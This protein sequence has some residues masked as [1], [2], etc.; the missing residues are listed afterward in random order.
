L[1]RESAPTTTKEPCDLLLLFQ[2]N[3]RDETK[4]PCPACRSLN[5]RGNSYP[6]FGV[7]SWECQNLICPARSAFDRGN[8]FSVWSLIKREAISSPENQIPSSSLKRWKLDLVPGATESESIEMLL[9]HF[10]LQG[11]GVSLYNCK[12]EVPALERR[13]VKH[14]LSVDR[15]A[16][17]ERF[18]ASA[19]FHRFAI[20]R[21]AHA[22]SSVVRLD[23]G[24]PRFTLFCG[25]SLEALRLI[26][27]ESIDGAVT[28]P[29][30]FNARSYSVWPNVY[31]Y[32]YD[33]YNNAREVYR[34]LKSGSYYLFNIFDYFD[35]ELVITDSAMGKKRLLLSGYVVELFRRIGFTLAGNVVWSKGEIEGKRNF[36]QGNKSPY[37]QLPLNSWEH[38]LIFQKPG[39]PDSPPEFPT[40]LQERPVIK[41]VRGENVLGHTAPFPEAIPELLIRTLRPDAVVLDPFGGSMT[42]ARVAKRFGVH[43]VS[44]D[45]HREYCELGIRLYRAAEFQ[46]RLDIDKPTDVE[47]P[48]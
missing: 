48:H 11:D 33:M 36:N 24:D 10:T 8:R 37:Y 19:I 28:S 20:P 47:R 3:L 25:D 41:M 45:L 22:D 44:M 5:V 2:K 18:R 38:V 13:V 39:G 7:K 6:T 43:A 16:T 21:P 12:E 14:S 17:Y 31:C 1:P 42:T 30:Y 29:P 46:Q 26:T 4:V 40:V 9:R 35:N 15:T 32:L 23:S 27:S 34:T